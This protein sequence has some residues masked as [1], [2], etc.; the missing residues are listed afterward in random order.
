LPR[1]AHA[2]L[3]WEV[4]EAVNALEP[5]PVDDA[6]LGQVNR[7]LRYRARLNGEIERLQAGVALMVR[8]IQSRI[9]TVDYL[10][11]ASAEEL[12]GRMLAG[13]KLRSIKTPYGVVGFRKSPAHLEVIDKDVVLQAVLAGFLPD[14]CRVVKADVGKVALNELFKSTGEIPVGTDLVPKR[15]SFYIRH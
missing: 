15:D 5:A 4:A 8:S 13:G 9:N 14:R 7:Y 11:R 10:Y 1:E 6:R 3:R 12:I 2:R